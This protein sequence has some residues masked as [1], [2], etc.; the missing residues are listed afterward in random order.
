MEKNDICE[1][2]EE[3]PVDIEICGNI[4]G[5]NRR[6]KKLCFACY[7]KSQKMLRFK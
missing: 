4:K 3:K 6:Y 7:K 1:K 5:H 2:C